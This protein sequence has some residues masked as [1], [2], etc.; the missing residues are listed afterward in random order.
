MR[1]SQDCLLIFEQIPIN[2]LT[3]YAY[4]QK[5]K[6]LFFLPEVIEGHIKQQIYFCSLAGKK[7][8]SFSKQLQANMKIFSSEYKIEHLLIALDFNREFTENLLNKNNIFFG[9]HR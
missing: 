2:N 6:Q 7:S 4:H 3:D 8:L 1:F 9:S 5:H